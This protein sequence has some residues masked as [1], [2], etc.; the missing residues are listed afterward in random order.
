M[1]S[2]EPNSGTSWGTRRAVLAHDGTK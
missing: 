2:L 1:P